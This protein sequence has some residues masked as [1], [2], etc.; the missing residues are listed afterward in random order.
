MNSNR[1]KEERP[2]YY[3]W[4]I[5][6]IYSVLTGNYDKDAVHKLL[7]RS[8]LYE[9]GSWD[10]PWAYNKHYLDDMAEAIAEVTWVVDCPREVYKVNRETIGIL[11]EVKDRKMSDAALLEMVIQRYG[12]ERWE[13][14]GMLIC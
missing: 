10:K 14:L 12:K 5:I 4:E 8:L 7:R 6:W 2:T 11:M 1:S 3:D 13:R 9:Y